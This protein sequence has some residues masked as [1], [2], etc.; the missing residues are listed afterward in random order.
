MNIWCY[1]LLGWMVFIGLIYAYLFYDIHIR[2][3][4]IRQRWKNLVE[5]FTE[6]E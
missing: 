1:I 3:I 2:R 6:E 5:V 4:N